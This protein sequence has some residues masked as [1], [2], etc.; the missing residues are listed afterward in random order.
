MRQQ[1]AMNGPSHSVGKRLLT[2]DQPPFFAKP[3][4]MFRQ[5][6]LTPDGDFLAGHLSSMALEAAYLINR[7]Y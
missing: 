2:S 1:T 6:G 3:R 7:N 5:T 4:L